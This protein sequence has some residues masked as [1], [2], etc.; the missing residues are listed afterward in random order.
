[1]LQLDVSMMEHCVDDHW[2]RQ[3]VRSLLLVLL[4]SQCKRWKPRQRD[5]VKKFINEKL[6]VA[7]GQ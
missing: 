1:M 2:L 3:R 6:P 5:V 4:A 7:V